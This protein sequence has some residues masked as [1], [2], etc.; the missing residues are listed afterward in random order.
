MLDLYSDMKTQ[1][2]LLSLTYPCK[3]SRKV[4]YIRSCKLVPQATHVVF[5]FACICKIVSFAFSV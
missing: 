4:L 2:Y 3:F 5:K 1:N